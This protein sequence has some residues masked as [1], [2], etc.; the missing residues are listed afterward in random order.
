MKG[1]SALPEAI[2]ETITA[3]GQN[4]TLPVYRIV[5]EDLERA[6]R[7]LQRKSIHQF[8]LLL[9]E[10][11]GIIKNDLKLA[12]NN[13]S[14]MDIVVAGQL[15][16]GGTTVTQPPTAA[17]LATHIDLNDNSIFISGGAEDEVCLQDL[18]LHNGK[19]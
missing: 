10:G 5:P 3:C 16:K 8:A 12:Y 4:K 19:V 1:I 18:D 7:E 15:P 14:G 11:L 6:I 9:S 17:Q 2:T 13:R